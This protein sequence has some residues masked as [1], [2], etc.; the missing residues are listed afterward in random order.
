ML[1]IKF[2]KEDL[3]ITAEGFVD[4][5]SLVKLFKEIWKDRN[6]NSIEWLFI[7]TRDMNDSRPSVNCIVKLL[8]RINDG[9]LW[10]LR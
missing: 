3:M 4:V 9:F 10:K 8:V 2:Y 7:W 5:S 6:G 1:E